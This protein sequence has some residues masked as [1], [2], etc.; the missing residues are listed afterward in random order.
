AHP[1]R[2]GVMRKSGLDLLDYRRLGIWRA[3]AG[4]AEGERLAAE[5]GRHY[6][7]CAAAFREMMG[8]LATA[9]VSIFSAQL[10]ELIQRF[11][12]F[13]QSA[14]VL[15]FDDLLHLTREVLRQ[16][17]TVR[18]AAAKRFTRVL[19]DE[20][21]DTDP[22]QAEII[23]F[24]TSADAPAKRWNERRLV[25]GRLFMVG[26]PKQAIY[27]FRGADIAT[28][29]LAR[30]SIER[31][32]PG[33]VVHV[34]ANFRSCDD[35]LRHI[36]QCFQTP[37]QGQESGYVALQPTRKGAEHG[38]PGVVKVRVDVIPQ[39]R[40]DDIRDEEARIVA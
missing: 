27:R 17:A 14:A 10:A 3:G 13:K 12:T 18:A 36:N 19:V 25:P 8:Q 7:A 20:F 5:A 37:L 24:L 23:F 22:I 39:S 34:A 1:A 2:V 9:L 35:I 30:A 40:V 28:Y 29:R 31:Q 4:K 16:Q 15:D 21:Q 32:F 11:E 33:N 38:L 26:D 6:Q